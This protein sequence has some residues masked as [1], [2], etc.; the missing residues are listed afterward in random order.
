M[1]TFF[2][3]PSFSFFL[4]TAAGE[5]ENNCSFSSVP[6]IRELVAHVFEVVVAH[7]V[8][9]QDEAALVLGNGVAYV[10]EQLLL[11]LAGLLVHLG[12]VVH[13]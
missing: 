7:V 8:E 13:L 1:T 3:S 11:L 9:A 10:L 12:E 5:G 4:F 2:P 6:G